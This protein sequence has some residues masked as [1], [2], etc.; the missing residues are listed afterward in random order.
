MQ[1]IASAGLRCRDHAFDIKI[2]T[3]TASRNFT[4]LISR[5]HMQRQC[6]V[7]RINRHR[8]NTRIRGS[9]RNANGDLATV[10]DQQ[11]AK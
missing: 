1:R 9:A 10:G 4:S 8:G 6:I 11:L 2:G 5:T 7:G 3:R